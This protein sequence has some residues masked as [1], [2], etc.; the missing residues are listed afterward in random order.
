[1]SDTVHILLVDDEPSTREFMAR[2]LEGETGYRVLRA[3]TG[4]EAIALAAE[5]R[6]P[7]VITDLY[8]PGAGGLGLCRSLRATPGLEGR[9]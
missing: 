6:P 2:L 1:M 5:H 9:W 3:G 7:V 8:M 4:E